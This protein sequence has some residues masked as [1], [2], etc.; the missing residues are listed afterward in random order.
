MHS[1]RQWAGAWLQKHIAD[2]IENMNVTASTVQWLP[3][4][5]VVTVVRDKHTFRALT[6]GPAL[7]CPFESLKSCTEHLRQVLKFREFGWVPPM[8]KSEDFKS[9][10]DEHFKISLSFFSRNYTFSGTRPCKGMESA[11]QELVFHSNNFAFS[12]FH[13]CIAMSE[14]KLIF[15]FC[16]GN[17][18]GCLNNSKATEF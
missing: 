3:T 18:R 2:A 9:P 4:T 13:F 7:Y 12:S 17:T 11:V 5:T 14:W 1:E 6:C 16:I 8:S 15:L 10:K